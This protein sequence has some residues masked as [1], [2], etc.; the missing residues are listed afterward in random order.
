MKQLLFSLLLP[1]IL[2]FLPVTTLYSQ[3]TVENDTIS[4]MEDE[5]VGV[6]PEEQKEWEQLAIDSVSSFFYRYDRRVNHYR[7]A[8]YSL[9]PTSLLVQCYGD[10]G[11]ISM[12]VGWEYGK[13]GE[14]G[15]YLLLGVIPKY[16]SSETKMT[17]TLK[18]S[19]TPWSFYLGN[20]ISIDPLTCGLYFNT[21]FSEHFWAKEPER[22][23]AG[24][25][26]FSTRIR[27]HIFLG[28]AITYD[29]P[30]KR[31]LF[32]RSA[33]LFYELSSCDIYIISAFNNRYLQPSDYLRL[34]VGL[35]FQ[36]F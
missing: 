21:V 5:L 17:L 11:L 9:I 14:W 6:E 31:R 30:Y 28:Q 1:S 8:F 35:K 26:G 27:S 12:G 4:L 18:Q 33:T 3:V 2:L 24:Y 19:Y 10:M 20:K 13:R 25:Y 32:T 22:Y 23:P 15:S 34:S 29:I 36:I 16:N 7:E